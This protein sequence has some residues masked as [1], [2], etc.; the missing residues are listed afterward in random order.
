MTFKTECNKMKW[1]SRWNYSLIVVFGVE[2]KMIKLNLIFHYK[3]IKWIAN[4]GNIVID[5]EKFKTTEQI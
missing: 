4:L 5:R 1:S 2:Y 3:M